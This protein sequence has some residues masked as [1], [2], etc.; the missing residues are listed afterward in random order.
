MHIIKITPL[1]ASLLC[2]LPAFAVDSLDDLLN[3]SLTSL[4][5]TKVTSATRTSQSLADTPAAVYVITAKEINRSGARSVA[6]ALALAPGLH[7]AKY[8]NYDWGISARGNN[9]VMSN[10]MLVM[11]DGRSVFKPMFSGVD[12]DLIPVSIDNIE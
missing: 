10:T 6:D 11:V 12:W 1:L 9:K 3:M 4:A 5:E 8:S 2:T 7:I